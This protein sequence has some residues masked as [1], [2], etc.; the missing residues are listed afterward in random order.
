[1]RHGCSGLLVLL[2]NLLFLQA[3][4]HAAAALSP[5]MERY[6]R[7]VYLLQRMGGPAAAERVAV[8]GRVA[9][10]DATESLQHHPDKIFVLQTIAD[11]LGSLGAFP[12]EAQLFEAY[13]RLALGERVRAASLLYAY[14]SVAPYQER[15]YALLTSLLHEQNESASLYLVCRE[16]EERDP[17]CNAERSLLTW[18]A[19]YAMGRYADARAA[20]LA[21]GNCLGGR[22]YLYA[23]RA[24]LAMGDAHGAESLVREAVRETQPGAD[25]AAVQTLWDALRSREVF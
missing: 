22:A 7:A 9:S 1:M 6:Y 10:C 2:V 8:P 20:A 21:P 24:A 11:D 16:W 23:A 17:A 14:V 4:G 5:R 18:T 12:P 13:T 3:S 25:A 15:H 19:L